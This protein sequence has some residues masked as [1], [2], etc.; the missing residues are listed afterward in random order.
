LSPSLTI[1]GIITLHFGL[2]FETMNKPFKFQLVF[3]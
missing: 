2:C 3:N 1:I